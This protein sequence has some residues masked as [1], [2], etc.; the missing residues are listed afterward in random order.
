M[1][2]GN[3][4]NYKNRM[5]FPD[6][7]VAVTLLSEKTKCLNVETFVGEI[8]IALH[9]NIY[10]AIELTKENELELQRNFKNNRIRSDRAR[11]FTSAPDHPWR[12][13]QIIQ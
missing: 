6:D 9:N 7:T 12:D 8:Y 1:P 11:S 5:Y 3:V 4:I 2:N 10:K 13:S